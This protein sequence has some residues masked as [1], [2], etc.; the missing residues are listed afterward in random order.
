MRFTQCAFTDTDTSTRPTLRIDL[1]YHFSAFP[2]FI[3]RIRRL[4]N[5]LFEHDF[6]SRRLRLSLWHIPLHLSKS[7]L[8][9]LSPNS[10]ENEISLYIIT[11]HS[12]IQIMKIKKVRE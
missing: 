7:F 1:P 8:N 12:N 5:E 3:V 10:D 4:K 6:G 9:P 11:T 2:P